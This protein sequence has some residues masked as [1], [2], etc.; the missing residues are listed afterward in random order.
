[1]PQ[2]N[3]AIVMPLARAITI[4]GTDRSPTKLSS[5]NAIAFS[6]ASLQVDIKTAYRRGLSFTSSGKDVSL[7]RDVFQPFF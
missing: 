4:T 6:E 5:F 2:T 3:I 1:M 7:Y